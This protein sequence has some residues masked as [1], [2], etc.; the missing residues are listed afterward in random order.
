M[1]ATRRSCL[2][3]ALWLSAVGLEAAGPEV[4]LLTAVKNTDTATVRALLQK[5]FDANSSEAD[6]TTALHWA[7]HRDNA[8][9]VDLLIGAGANAASANRYGVK[10]LMIAAANG[11]ALIIGRLLNAGASPNTATPEGETALMTAARNGNP[12]A[13]TLLIAHGADVNAREG[14]L[15]QTA[16]MWAAAENNVA[17]VRQLIEAGADIHAKTIRTV[18]SRPGGSSPP[19]GSQARGDSSIVNEVAV[20]D[21]TA[22][23]DGA[24]AEIEATREARRRASAT[25]AGDRDRARRGSGFTALAFAVRAGHSESIRTL[26]D[27]GS[28]VNEAVTDG[29]SML[30]LAIINAHFDLA[31]FLLDRG[32]DP[33]GAGPGWTPLHR[34]VWT[35]RPNIG[36]VNPPAVPT[37]SMD[38]IALA[39][40]LLA[41]GADVNARMSQEKVD[42]NRNN[43][44]RIGATPF[45]LA[46]QSCDT[47]LM[48][49]LLSRGADPLLMTEDGTTPLM[50][51]AGVGVYLPGESPGT[52]AEC[53]DAV[54]L[55]METGGRGVDVN[56]MRKDGYRAIHGAAHRGASSLI[57]FLVDMGA[58]LDVVTKPGAGDRSNKNGWTPLDIADGVQYSVNLFRY[59]ETAALIRRLMKERGLQ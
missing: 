9:I 10:P 31:A 35:R 17:A 48:R 34:L 57:Q 29:T 41:R 42:E 59:P 14:W 11:N 38:T 23:A 21:G 40:H 7:V 44:D 46:S 3:L 2:W 5:H 54:K 28:S 8:E 37:G 50:A 49:L 19:A 36:A 26:L 13:L 58:R 51:A 45:L 24:A 27:A 43:L 56:A 33:N 39:E 18:Q 55:A 22:A 47:E 20:A 53:L 12:A 4:P 16:L 25:G 32:A 1:H 6:G 52:E 30:H 15:G